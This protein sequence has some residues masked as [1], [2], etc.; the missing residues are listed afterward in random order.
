[1]KKGNWLVHQWEIIWKWK[2]D[3]NYDI[4]KDAQKGEQ[5]IKENVIRVSIVWTIHLDDLSNYQGWL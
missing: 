3:V 1:M 2:R 4:E 5:M